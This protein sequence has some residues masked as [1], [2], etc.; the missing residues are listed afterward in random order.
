[1]G[2]DVMSIFLEDEFPLR[3]DGT[4]ASPTSTS[5]LLQNLNRAL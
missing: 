5:S 4:T 2:I 1:M 3:A